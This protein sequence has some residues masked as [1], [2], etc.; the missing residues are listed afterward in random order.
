MTSLSF[1]ETTGLSLN[2][3][4][5]CHAH[6]SG[7]R[8][9]ITISPKRNGTYTVNDIEAGAN[10]SES[11]DHLELRSLGFFFCTGADASVN[12][13][14]GTG[15]V[16]YKYDS[17]ILGGGCQRMIGTLSGCNNVAWPPLN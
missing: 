14:T 6:G 17:G 15:K 4:I 8:W 16:S 11:E 13:R 9:M 3:N 12:L 7:G 2:K 10:L 1:A 5:Y